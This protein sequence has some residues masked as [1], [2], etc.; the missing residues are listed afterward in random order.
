MGRTRQPR[1]P[2]GATAPADPLW[3][4][5]RAAYPPRQ[6]NPWTEARGLLIRWQPCPEIRE[7]AH[8]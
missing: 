5:F 6:G 4:R 2:L 1:L 3:E 8:D 7:P